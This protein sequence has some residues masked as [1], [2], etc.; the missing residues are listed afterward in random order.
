MADVATSKDSEYFY[1]SIT[2]SKDIIALKYNDGVRDSFF[3]IDN[4]LDI[5]VNNKTDRNFKIK[6]NEMRDGKYSLII[7]FEDRSYEIHYFTL[8]FINNIKISNDTSSIIF[9]DY[10][11]FDKNKL[12]TS[13]TKFSFIFSPTKDDTNIM[14]LFNLGS[15]IEQKDIFKYI[16]NVSKI[17]DLLSDNNKISI[18]LNSNNVPQEYLYGAIILN[19]SSKPIAIIKTLNETL[20][21]TNDLSFTITFSII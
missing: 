11:P 4:G 12:I 18:K 15:H 6:L 9:T 1:I 8:S 19:S 17:T 5:E 21:D 7:Y 3:F 2:S 20:I 10:A 16:T 14:N 13:M